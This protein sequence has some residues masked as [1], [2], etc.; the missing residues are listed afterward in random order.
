M[1][2]EQR[3]KTS[4]FLSYILRHRPDEI[5]VELDRAGYVDVDLLLVRA[6]EHGHSI[7]DEALEE[8]VATNDKQRFEFSDDR[9]MIRA[10]QGHSVQVELGYEPTVPPKTLY[11]GTADR[12][13]EAIGRE[14]L[15]ERPAAPC[16]PLGDR[17]DGNQC[18]AAIRK[19]C[20]ADDRDREDAGCW[21]CVLPDRQR[22]MAGGRRARGVYRA[23]IGNVDGQGGDSWPGR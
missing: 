2:N 13:L 3:V 6:T 7:S 5:G 23:A 20:I 17:T 8:V 19:A 21:P 11:H 4:K 16:A 15:K 22:R 10:R 9:A 14:G 1:T 18:R 12:N